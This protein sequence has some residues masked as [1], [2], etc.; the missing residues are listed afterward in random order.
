LSAVL[1]PSIALA[2]DNLSERIEFSGFARVVAGY[3][4]EDSASYQ[5]YSNNLS[6]SEQSLVAL[7]ADIK[8][9]DTIN[10]S[11]QLLAHSGDDRK[12]GV[13]WMYLSYEPNQNWRFKA[14]KLRTPFFRHSDVLDVGFAY[15]WITPPQQVY[16]AFLFSD[17]NGLTGTYRFN[18]S[19]LNFE[20]EAYYGKYDGEFTSGNRRVDLVVDEI[21][22]I[23][24]S[25]TRGNLSMRISSFESS[26]FYADIPEFEQL[27]LALDQAGFSKNAESLRFN[28]EAQ[29]YQA[30]INY[31]TLDY[32]FAA[33]WMKIESDL[34]AVPQV[35]A[36]YVTAGYNF[37]PF[38][39]H[40]T[41]S[42]SN[43][44]NNTV[45]NM[46]PVGVAPQL[47][48]LY[49][50]YDQVLSARALYSLDSLSLGLRW[51]FR[52]NMSMKAEVTFLDGKKDEDA[53]FSDITDPNFDRQATLYQL[54]V[55]WVF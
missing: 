31:D 15:P 18:V 2:Q 24:I 47:D 38:Q 11:T 5:G 25:A 42:V 54:A 49:Y 52:R 23:I 27:S 4:D 26:D 41:Y 6:L 8:I 37:Y 53:F 32:F 14:G 21:K 19:S 44:T 35:D 43:S 39:I 3:L 50:A 36:A 34:I 13:E 45:D 48:Q 33:E 55:E 17:Y 16:S 9:T 46:I 40:L 7:Q 28:G 22:G 30:N 10:F 20:L 51:D 1:A 29:G 12:S